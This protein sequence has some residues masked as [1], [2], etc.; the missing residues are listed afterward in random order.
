MYSGAG[1]YGI[2]EILLSYAKLPGFLPLPVAVQ[3]GWLRH[4]TTF[5]TSGNPPEIWVD[6]QRIASELEAFY[7]KNKI[8]IVGSFYYY[9]MAL[10]KDELPTVVRSGSICIAPHS[11][12][13]VSTVYSV[14]DFA[15]KLNELGNEYKPITV[16]LYFLDMISG[17]IETYEKYGFEVVSNGSLFDANFLRNFVRNVHDKQHCIFSDLGS[18]VLF[19]ADMGLNLVRIDVES[20]YVDLGQKHGTEEQR[21]GAKMFDEKFLRS[22]DKERVASELGKPYLLSPSEVR[23]AMLRNYFTWSFAR[24]LAGNVLGGM[25]HGRSRARSLLKR[26]LGLD[27]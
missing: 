12:H 20:R 19:A 18:G 3:H 22:L 1:F 16:M 11:S 25:F 13:F 7:P 5:E 4:A 23:R 17:T 9:L 15:R 2:R 6:S 26:M 14:E 27:A 8:R 21:S 24:R 10:L